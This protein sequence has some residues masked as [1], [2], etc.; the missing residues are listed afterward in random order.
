MAAWKMQTGQARAVHNKSLSVAMQLSW[1]GSKCTEHLLS[2]SNH[3]CVMNTLS[4]GIATTTLCMLDYSWQ[5]K[6]MYLVI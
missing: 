1:P 4:R 2:P 3:L 6:Y 5:K